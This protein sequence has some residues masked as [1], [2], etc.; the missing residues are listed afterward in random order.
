V[1]APFGFDADTCGAAGGFTGPGTCTVKVSYT[2]TLAGTDR[3]TLTISECPATGT[4]IPLTIYLDGGGIP[5]TPTAD[6]AYVVFGDV[7]FYVTVSR[8]V[9]ITV[10]A[11]FR[12]SPGSVSA[13]FGFDAD[14]CGVAGGFTG[15]GTCT[16][17]VSYTPTLAGTDR[18]ALTIS[19]CAAT[20]T[21]IPLTITVEGDGE[22]RLAAPTPPSLTFPATGV[23]T[24]SAAQ[25]VTLT[26]TGYIPLHVGALAATGDF[27]LSADS[28]SGTTVAARASCSAGVTFTPTAAG[29]RS[30]TLTFADDSTGGPQ[31]V[32]LSGSGART[33]ASVTPSALNFA[34]RIVGTTSPTRTVK[35]LNTGS[36]DL[37]VRHLTVGGDFAIA[38]AGTCRVGTVVA[39]GGSCTVT[40]TFTPTAVGA[41]QG[42][43][44]IADTS[45]TTPHVLALS[46]SGTGRPV[47]SVSPGQL[48]FGAQAVGAKSAGKTVVV[49]NQG[50]ASLSFAQIYTTGD[51]L[52]SGGTRGTATSVQPG[53]TCTLVVKF[54]PRARGTRVG[55]LTFEDN[56]STSPQAVALSGTGA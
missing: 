13:P 45:T 44:K 19:E 22:P 26:N 47:F 43:L 16:V 56:A 8:S 51:F 37:L 5:P 35:L 42:A 1:S 50:T 2:P 23:G 20:G 9:T 12:F 7:P 31:T 24:T 30:G 27:G 33:T 36:V 48:S 6:P 11:G 21:C 4:C 10:D 32:A 53:Q 54:A 49:S 28:C 39:A 17:K 25:T 34:A 14:T 41:R 55:A 52:R 18:N 3:N 38:P 15:P 40:I 46:G 29:L